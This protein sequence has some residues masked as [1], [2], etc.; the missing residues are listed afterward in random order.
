MRYEME[1]S[2]GRVIA[3]KVKFWRSGQSGVRF[4]VRWDALTS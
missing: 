1:F 4:G 3:G 2:G